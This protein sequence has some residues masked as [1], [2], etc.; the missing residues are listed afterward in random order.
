M[1]NSDDINEIIRDEGELH[2]HPPM[3]WMIKA[4]WGFFILSILLAV[5]SF[6]NL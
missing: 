2:R 4:F 6:L 5:F 1:K 3:H